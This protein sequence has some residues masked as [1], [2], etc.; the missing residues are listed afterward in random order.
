MCD[1]TDS[2]DEIEFKAKTKTSQELR[3][4][5]AAEYTERQKRVKQMMEIVDKEESCCEK[6][7]LRLR[8][9]CMWILNRQ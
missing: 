1:F 6:M 7:K 4:A 9:F 5:Y 8:G 2:D 3:E